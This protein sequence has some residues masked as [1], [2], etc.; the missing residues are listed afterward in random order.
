MAGAKRREETS[1]VMG[2]TGRL[3]YDDLWRRPGYLIRRLHQIHI[4]LFAEEMAGRDLT[5]VQYAILTV[6]YPSDGL[7]QL[8]LSRAVGIDRTSG[9]DV[10]KRLVRRS[11][12]ACEPS[13]TDRRA[14][15]VTI[16]EAGRALVLEMRPAMERA[17]DKLVAPL[18]EEE[19]EVF[20]DTLHRLVRANND[21]SR[22]PMD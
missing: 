11:L 2:A 1:E 8:S 19:Q 16:T 7:D 20:L 22:A 12:V 10:I 14:K 9:A 3:H 13:P 17:Q 4:G 6:L 21:A 15:V 18:S 5:A